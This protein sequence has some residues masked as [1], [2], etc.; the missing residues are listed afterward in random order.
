MELLTKAD[1]V[2]EAMDKNMKRY[3]EKNFDICSDKCLNKFPV[4]K[5]T[6]NDERCMVN[7][8]NLRN[9]FWYEENIAVSEYVKTPISSLIDKV[10]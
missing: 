6:V 7:C 8:Y 9:H 10:N 4:A 2:R 1:Q 5:F 3:L